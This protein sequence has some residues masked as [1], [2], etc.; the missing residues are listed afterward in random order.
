MRGNMGREGWAS[1][2]E[3]MGSRGFPTRA[4]RLKG[5]SAEQYLTCP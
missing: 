3:G 2:P 4:W 5:V 1:E